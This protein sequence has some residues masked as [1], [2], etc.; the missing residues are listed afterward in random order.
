[1]IEI[2][3]GIES[4]KLQL[5]FLSWLGI[6]HGGST[7]W[8]RDRVKV[9]IVTFLAVLPV[10]QMDLNRIP[11]HHPDHRSWNGAIKTPEPIIGIVA[12]A[13]GELGRFKVNDDVGRRGSIDGRGNIGRGRD[14]RLDGLHRKPGIGEKTQP[15]DSGAEQSRMTYTTRKTNRHR[16]S[17][18]F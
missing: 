1:M 17:F 13:T 18:D 11:H 8:S 4:L 3:A 2:E 10:L 14:L 16:A 7:A 6:Q 9:D 5:G 15:H 12:Q